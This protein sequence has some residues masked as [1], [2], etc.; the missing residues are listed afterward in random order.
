MTTK[1]VPA[2][3]YATTKHLM[4]SIDLMFSE[5]GA[6]DA[7]IQ[8]QELSIEY[9]CNS[10][11]AT[12]APIGDFLKLLYSG[13]KIPHGTHD[14]E[15]LRELAS[16][17]YLVVTYALFEKML[18]G[19]IAEYKVANPASVTAWKRQNGAGENLPPLQELVLNLPAAVGNQLK[20]RPEFKLLEY[21][22]LVRV[23]NSHVKDTTLSSVE[24][25]LKAFTPA[26]MA[27]FRT[28]DSSTSPNAPAQIRFDDFLL[29]TRAIKYY[30]KLLN[31][32]CA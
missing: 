15:E 26:E 6:Q 1:E 8:L 13:N 25:A 3:G 16:K 7:C 30:S 19:I 4:P 31:E 17:S 21:Y 10:A 27:H 22:R 23:A 9:L 28:Y 2:P 24:K 5:L 29:F 14:F 12:R 11:A 18:R 20:S 32:A